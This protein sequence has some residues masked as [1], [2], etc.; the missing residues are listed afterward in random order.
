MKRMGLFAACLL[1]LLVLSACFLPI[2]SSM[3]KPAASYETLA[4]ALADHPK[5]VLPRAASV[6][7]ASEYLIQLDGRSRIAGA[8]GYVISGTTE[9]NQLL[10]S[11]TRACVENGLPGAEPS[12]RDTLYRGIHIQS[13]VLPS[14]NADRITIWN[15]FTI[16]NASYYFS[17]TYS[18]L[19]PGN[20]ALTEQF[21]Q[22]AADT[23]LAASCEIIDDYVRAGDGA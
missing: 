2:Y 15:R 1:I 11:S 6:P 22:T 5:V 20:P 13:S 9:T 3:Q 16:G 21:I 4:K 12:G 7:W 17:D 23:L 10:I 18:W 19:T 8:T 14:E